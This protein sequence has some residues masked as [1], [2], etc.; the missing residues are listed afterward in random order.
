MIIDGTEMR[1]RR[2]AAG[3]KDREKFS[4]GKDKQNAVK[5]MVVTDAERR[6]LFC[7]PAEPAGCADITHTRKLGLVTFLPRGP[8][9]FAFWR[10]RRGK[11][12]RA[13]QLPDGVC[14]HP[15]TLGA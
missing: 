3:G 7:G 15:A 1:V 9:H 13:G 11:L 14:Y 10:H 8:G 2:H 5:S 12:G 4:S 6:L